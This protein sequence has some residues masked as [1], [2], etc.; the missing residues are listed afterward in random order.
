[1]VV[2][3]RETIIIFFAIL[4]VA[5]W[6]FDRFYYTPQKKKITTLKEE[7][8]AA[9][10]K[11]KESVLF[12]REVE[13]V[14]AEVVRLEKELQSLSDKMF[15][16]EEFG[17]FLKHLS[18]ESE[19]LQMKMISMTSQEEKPTPPEG[20]KPL[21]AFQYRR[22]AIQMVLRS[23]LNAV[24]TYLKGIEQLP[25]LAAVDHLQVERI[26]DGTSFLR[27]T[28]GLSVFVVL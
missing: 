16:G 28:M 3:K 26:G 21:S 22:V 6:V 2:K 20:K 10:L 9:D 8:K 19:R 24:E 1:M 27:V 18:D 7:A 17:A 11:L 14:E 23:R 15:R 4:A 13:T 25:F 12:T 5:I